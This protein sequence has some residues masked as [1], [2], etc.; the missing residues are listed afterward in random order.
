MHLITNTIPST[1]CKFQVQIRNMLQ[2]FT[3]IAGMGKPPMFGDY[4]AQRHWMEITTNL[5]PRMWY[6]FGPAAF[7]SKLGSQKL[8]FVSHC[9]VANAMGSSQLLLNPNYSSISIQ[10]HLTNVLIFHLRYRNSSAN[11][12]QYWGLDYPPLTA[13]HAWICGQISMLIE[14]SWTEL[15]NLISPHLIRNG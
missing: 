5:H 9:G 8:T 14:P 4:E 11:D 10:N 1:K 7:A 12:L 6:G 13:A 3:S 15:G 2:W